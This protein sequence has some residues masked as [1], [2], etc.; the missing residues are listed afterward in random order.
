[1]SCLVFDYSIVNYLYAIFSGYFISFG[2]ERAVF[3]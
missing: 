2:G 3:L 1:M